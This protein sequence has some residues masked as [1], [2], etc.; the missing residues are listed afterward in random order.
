MKI[1]FGKFGIKTS[2]GQFTQHKPDE[3]KISSS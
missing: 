3:I 1:D 2:I